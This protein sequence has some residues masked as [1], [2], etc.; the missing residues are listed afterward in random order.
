MEPER[1]S[2]NLDASR[3]YQEAVDEYYADRVLDSEEAFICIHG[4]A[5]TASAVPNT[6]AAAQLSFVGDNYAMERNG[7]P[8]RI[9][10]VS[11]QTGVPE[12]PITM[13][14]RREQFASRVA[15][16][17][18]QR[19]AHIKGV[20]SALRVL[21]GR[22][23]GLDPDGEL[24]TTSNG[25]VHVLNAHALVNSTLCSSIKTPGS[26]EGQGSDQMHR[27]CVAHLRAVLEHLEPTIVHSQGRR[28]AVKH[29]T[30]HRSM[31]AAVDAIEWYD[32][33]VAIATL[34]DR[35]F[36]WVS[37]GHPSAKGKVAWQHPTSPYFVA[38]VGPALRRA[39]DLALD[40]AC[41]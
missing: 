13:T 34:G 16:T 24:L 19:N 33:H 38:V 26:M 1:I 29:P 27:N 36:V 22:E 32:E 20:T 2:C 3:R 5:C 18:S 28:A 35:R 41:R 14:R 12:A 39:H 25:D 6:F 31:L 8:W 30:P 40:L 10:V 9:V 17:F 7:M 23:A 11:M 37:L 21:W 15:E 4:G